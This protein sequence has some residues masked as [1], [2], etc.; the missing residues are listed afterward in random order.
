MPIKSRLVDRGSRLAHGALHLA[1][2]SSRPNHAL[3]VVQKHQHTHPQ[4]LQLEHQHPHPQRSLHTCQ[5]LHQLSFPHQCLL[6]CRAYYQLMRH[7]QCQPRLPVTLQHCCQLP[8]PPPQQSSL[9][10]YHHGRPHLTQHRH[11]QGTP[12]PL[13]QWVRL[14]CP[15]MCQQW[16]QLKSHPRLQAHRRRTGPPWNLP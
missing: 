14:R 1:E 7:L 8:S 15:H 4:R 10:M 16:P 12:A 3:H 5:Q 11:Q 2:L 9:H 13:L 6:P